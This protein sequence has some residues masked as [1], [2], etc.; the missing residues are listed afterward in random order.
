MTTIVYTVN[1]NFGCF[2]CLPVFILIVYTDYDRVVSNVIRHKNS[3]TEVHIFDSRPFIFVPN[4]KKTLNGTLCVH[5][6]NVSQ[7]VSI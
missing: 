2:L 7:N 6:V 1:I 5:N 3:K 4:E